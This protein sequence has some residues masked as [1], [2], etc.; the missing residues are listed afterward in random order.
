[1][2]GC[3]KYL[4]FHFTCIEESAIITSYIRCEDEMKKLNFVKL[5]VIQVKLLLFLTIDMEFHVT[6]AF[7]SIFVG[8]LHEIKYKQSSSFRLISTC[9]IR[10]S[11]HYQTPEIIRV[12]FPIFHTK[13]TVFTLWILNQMQNLFYFFLNQIFS[14]CSQ[15]VYFQFH[16]FPFLSLYVNSF[17]QS[18][19]FYECIA[20]GVIDK[21]MNK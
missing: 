12:K 5:T 8:N 1:M 10:I 3:L 4:P 11:A 21:Q 20:N 18:E 16:Q 6:F 7:F 15:I 13:K 2:I 9:Y 19:W 14:H 17:V